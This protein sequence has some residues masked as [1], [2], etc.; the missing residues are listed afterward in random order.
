MLWRYFLLLGF[1]WLGCASAGQGAPASNPA[2]EGRNSSAKKKPP[3]IAAPETHKV[4]RGETVW[5][6][7][8]LHG[9]SVG[10]LMDL[11][12]LKDATLREGQTLK[13]PR[14]V[15]DPVT[16]P[17]SGRT[18]I[19]ARGETLRAIALKYGV[20]LEALARANPRVDADQPK[21]GL[22]LII[23][24]D[25]STPQ[26]KT[27]S[28]PPVPPPP[29][30]VHVVMD[31]DTFYSIAK[32]YGVT[33]DAIAM[34]NP[35]V[36]PERLRPGS[37]LAIPAKPGVGTGAE[38]TAPVVSREKQADDPALPSGGEHEARPGPK[39]RRYIVS[40]DE[41]PQTISE[42][43][44]IPVSKLYEM[45]GLKPGAPMKPGLEIQVPAL[46]TDDRPN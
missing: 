38:K 7:A 41:T 42:A 12:G 46:A 1:A 16:A 19:V 10:D 36:K 20:S 31:N 25:P 18:H 37:S 11:N 23:P 4:K 3:S 35:G 14:I 30:T 22:E 43:F 17:A 45:N 9:V 39:T 29:G 13:I 34:A 15:S 33:I 44:N 27:D 24:A 8:R 26:K 5:G 40:A 32:K 6:I 2:T 21:V 28:H